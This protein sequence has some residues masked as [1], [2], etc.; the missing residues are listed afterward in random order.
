VIFAVSDRE[1]V[2]ERRASAVQAAILKERGIG[3][4]ADMGLRLADAATFEVSVRLPDISARIRIAGSATIDANGRLSL[5]RSRPRRKQGKHQET[6]E[7][8]QVPSS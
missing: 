7:S 6:E 5:R 1:R 3:C 4:T 8:F 2:E